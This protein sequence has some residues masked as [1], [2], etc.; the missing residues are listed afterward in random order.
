MGVAE[1]AATLENYEKAIKIYEQV[2]AASLENN[3]LK[4]AAKEHFFRASLCHLCVDMLNAQ[5]AVQKYEEQYPAFGDSREAKLVKALIKH[6]ED[7]DVEAFT[8][9]VKNFDQISRL[10]QWYTTILLRIKK[11]MPDD[12]ELCYTVC[13]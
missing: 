1:Y 12:N 2:A 10:D 3:L 8:A 4:Y 7:E 11:Q 6:L 5:H 13:L 9:E